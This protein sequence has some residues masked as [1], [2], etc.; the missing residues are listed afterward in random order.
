LS[1][2]K[3][4]TPLR[5]LE[6]SLAAFDYRQEKAASAFSKSEKESFPDG[7]GYDA[8]RMK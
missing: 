4:T 2:E 6:V 1:F 3:A 5:T 7:G 8:A